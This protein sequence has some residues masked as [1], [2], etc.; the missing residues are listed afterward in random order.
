MGCVAQLTLK[1]KGF[2]SRCGVVIK[3]DVVFS[4]STRDTTHKRAEVLKSFSGSR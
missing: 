2:V 1:I 3:V 4:K